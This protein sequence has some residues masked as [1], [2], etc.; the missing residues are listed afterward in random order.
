MSDAGSGNPGG[1]ASASGVGVGADVGVGVAFGADVFAGADV[2][3][4]AD[5]VGPGSLPPEPQAVTAQVSTSAPTRTA[6]PRLAVM[7]PPSPVRPA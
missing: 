6:V 4:V 1:R 3:G 5:G 2:E 7:P